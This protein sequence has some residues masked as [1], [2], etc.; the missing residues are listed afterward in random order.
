MQDAED[1]LGNEGSEGLEK[2]CKSKSERI[3]LCFRD[4]TIHKIPLFKIT[5]EIT[6]SKLCVTLTQFKCIGLKV[7]AHRIGN[8][9]SS[10]KVNG[11]KIEEEE[12]AQWWYC[13]FF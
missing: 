2:K 7:N 1:Y 12:E 9:I 5:T 11:I 8:L 6:C 10:L 3:S 4:Q 13:Y